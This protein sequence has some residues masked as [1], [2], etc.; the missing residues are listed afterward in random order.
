MLIG[1]WGVQDGLGI[2]LV[3]FVGRLVVRVRFFG[4]LG[5]LLGSFWGAPGVVL[6]LLGAFCSALRGRFGTLDACMPCDDR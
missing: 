1:P 4:S 2:V 5:P 6:A 3:R